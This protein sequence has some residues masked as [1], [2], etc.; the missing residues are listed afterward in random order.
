MLLPIIARSDPDRPEIVLE[1]TSAIVLSQTCD[2]AHRKIS[3]VLGAVVSYQAYVD[4]EAAR[5]NSFVASRR[6]RKAV[7]DGAL[8]PQVVLR[9]SVAGERPLPWSLADFR[10]TYALPFNDDATALAGSLNGRLRL[11]PPY[12]EH[13]A[14]SFARFHMRVGLPTDATDF[15]ALG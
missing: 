14:Q 2:L 10:R 15:E 12:C 8:A 13:L 1:R 4:A 6:F 7:L 11:R 5:G 3:Q 9:P